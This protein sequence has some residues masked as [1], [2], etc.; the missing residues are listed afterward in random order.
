MR[1]NGITSAECVVELRNLWWDIILHIQHEGVL[2]VQ[3]FREATRERAARPLTST[4]RHCRE[5]YTYF[6]IAPFPEYLTLQ[7]D[8]LS[9]FLFTGL[10]DICVKDDYF[11]TFIPIKYVM[12]Y[13]GASLRHICYN[14]APLGAT[15][16]NAWPLCHGL[17]VGRGREGEG[18]GRMSSQ[19]AEMSDDA[20]GFGSDPADGPECRPSNSHG[21]P[22]AGTFI[23]VKVKAAAGRDTF[24]M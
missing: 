7:T 20:G 17:T 22:T 2:Y 8:S 11:Y 18:A 21:R 12:L 16:R 6:Y 5:N 14:G 4:R 3:T 23:N 24:C 15:L 13:L 19:R 9:W 10:L 1:P